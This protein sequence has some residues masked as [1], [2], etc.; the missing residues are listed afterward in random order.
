MAC[1]L[2]RREMLRF[3]TLVLPASLF[4]YRSKNYFDEE[5]VCSHV[6]RFTQALPTPLL[7]QQGK[8]AERSQNKSYFQVGLPELILC[9]TEI[10]FREMF[11]YYWPV[12]RPEIKRL[13]R[14]IK[15]LYKQPVIEDIDNLSAFQK[16]LQEQNNLHGG[17]KASLAVIFTLNDYTKPGCFRLVDVCRSGGIDELLIFKDPSRP[18]YLCSYP[19]QQKGF[20]RP[21]P[22]GAGRS[23]TKFWIQ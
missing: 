9:R 6:Y 22:Y 20:K 14:S 7:E 21:P 15:I 12:T 5:L 2:S 10:S 17:Q 16:V 1:S 3:L 13:Q 19:S 8:T 11:Q 18:P 23:K 4:E